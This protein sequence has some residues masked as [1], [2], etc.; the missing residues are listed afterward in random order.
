MKTF[1][2]ISLLVAIALTAASCGRDGL[3]WND[4]QGQPGQETGYLSFENWD[5]TVTSDEETSKDDGDLSEEITSQNITR[6]TTEATGDYIVKIINSSKEEVGNYTYDEIKSLGTIELPQDTYTVTAESSNYASMPDAEWETPAYYG[7]VSVNVI[8]KTQTDVNNLI[9]R[10]ANIKTTVELSADLNALFKPDDADQQLTT[11]LSLGEHSLVFGREETR[12]GFFKA[13]SSSNTIKIVLSG[14]YNKAGEG[15]EPS[16]VPITWTQELPNVKAGQWRKIGIK[17]LHASDGNVQFQVTVETWVYD[18]KIDVDVMSSLYNY[19]EEEIID[20][21]I[22]DE[23]APVLSLGGNH[24]VEDPF[25]INDDIFNFNIDQCTDHIMA[26]FTPTSGSTVASLDVVFDSD[27]AQFLSALQTAGFA[28][29]TIALWPEANPAEEYCFVS[30][31]GSNLEVTAKY[32]GMKGLYDY[33]GTHTA[34]FIAVDS[35]GRRSYT[36][37]TI[38]VSHTGGG[39]SDEGPSVIWSDGKGGTTDFGV[40]HEVTEAGL[41]VIIDITSETGITGLMVRI[42]SDMLTGDILT[43][44]N[45]AEEMDLINPASDAMNEAL[46]GL[47]FPTKDEVSGATS[48]KIDITNFMPALYGVAP[49]NTDFELTIS[50]ASGTTVKSIMLHVDPNHA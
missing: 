28:D 26:I 46:K 31:N 25:Q 33:T 36:T 34:K 27:N 18:E 5:L 15:Q 22:S 49:G 24:K 9:C 32:A 29:N 40:R 20:E 3:D 35:E 11:T 12:A 42:K 47:G 13:Q 39:G 4:G 14:S 50:D 41:P 48:L 30:Q 7:S 19:G 10:L 17:I 8:K 16:Y 2:K 38:V 21:E 23:N 37:L 1:A 45:L 6:A 44:L 43:E